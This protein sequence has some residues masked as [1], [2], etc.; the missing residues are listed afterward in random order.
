MEYF[1]ILS[2]FILS[3]TMQVFKAAFPE[4]RR[5]VDIFYTYVLFL[6]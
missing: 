6:N 4:S 1:P 2:L 3:Q 5:G